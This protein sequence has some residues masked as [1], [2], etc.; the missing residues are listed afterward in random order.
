VTLRIYDKNVS[1]A[2]LVGANKDYI[3]KQIPH[4][5]S[6]LCNTIDEVI[7]GSEVIVVGN[8]APEFAQAVMDCRSDQ[9]V[10]DLVR[11]PI[12]G[13]L[14]KADYRGICW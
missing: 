11:L 8:Q 1:L 6:L 7:Q 14:V 3:V 2:K 13:S 10:I 9:I 12:Y 4:L 5:S